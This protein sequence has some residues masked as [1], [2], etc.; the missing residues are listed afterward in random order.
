MPPTSKISIH[1]HVQSKQPC[2]AK[3]HTLVFG[4]QEISCNPLEGE[5]MQRTGCRTVTGALMDGETNIRTGVVGKVVELTYHKTVIPRFYVG[6]TV[7]VGV[8][9][10][11]CRGI[12]AFA[13]FSNPNVMQ[14]L[15]NQPKLCER[16]RFGVG[17]FRDL[18]TEKSRHITFIL[19]HECLRE[20]D[21]NAIDD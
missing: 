18:D 2:R 12:F 16:N 11:V 6:W 14:Y 4:G 5:F 21:N 13:E 7:S 8:K 17:V 9:D 20:R 19:E 1:K 3:E 15:I 10:A